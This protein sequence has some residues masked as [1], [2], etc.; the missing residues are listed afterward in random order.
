M[1]NEILKVFAFVLLVDSH[2]VIKPYFNQ[3]LKSDFKFVLHLSCLNFI[4][5]Y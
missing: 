3:G 4:Y 1:L 2:H 5:L